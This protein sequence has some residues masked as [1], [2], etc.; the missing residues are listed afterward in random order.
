MARARAER[1]RNGTPLG[2]VPRCS[3][4]AAHDRLRRSKAAFTADARPTGVLVRTTAKG[5]A[6]V[7]HPGAHPP[8]GVSAS[9]PPRP[10]LPAPP[11]PTHA[12]RNRDPLEV[13]FRRA[14]REA[15]AEQR[16][17]AEPPA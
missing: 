9:S 12:W 5:A 11:A 13:A 6:A 16:S 1:P 3:W 2:L 10:A 14:Q 8:A 17:A 7:G 4:P 15:K